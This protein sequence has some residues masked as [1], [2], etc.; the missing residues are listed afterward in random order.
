MAKDHHSWNNSSFHPQAFQAK[1]KL[2]SDFGNATRFIT[3]FKLD[4][5]YCPPMRSWLYWDRTRFRPDDSGQIL[6]LVARSVER[7]R[8]TADEMS[9]HD[10]AMN[11]RKWGSTSESRSRLESCEK[12]AQ[13]DPR[14]TVY[15][16]QLDSDRFLLNVQNGVIDLREG[17]LKKHDR[18]YLQS[19]IADVSYDPDAKCPIFDQ[20]LAR[21]S[22]G[23]PEWVSFIHRLFGYSLT[24]S[25]EEE[26]LFL[27]HGSGQNGKTKLLEIIGEILG[28]YG[29]TADF[30]TFLESDSDRIRNDIARMQGKR[31]ITAS[32]PSR[33][34]A[35]DESVVKQMTG[36]DTL[37]ARF[38]N[39]EFFEFTPSHTIVMATNDLPQVSGIDQGIWRRLVVVQFPV[40]ITDQERDN[41][42]L[43]KLQKEKSGILNRLV[44]GCLDW[45]KSGLEMPASVTQ[46]SADYRAEADSVWAFVQD[47][48]EQI[49]GSYVV[50]SELRT[51]YDAWC[52][53]H[54][55]TPA[56][57]FPSRLEVLGFESGRITGGTRIRY[58]LKLK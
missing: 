36:G 35:L 9:D 22:G 26:R 50:V 7:Y 53:T 13:S 12:I 32:E 47:A 56:V 44:Q 6:R 2:R 11:V 52:K 46:A 37:T 16:W 42:L 15:P 23:D 58:G 55:K 40:N 48:C 29:Q 18:K 4:I 45:Q 10:E 28:D 30:D 38:L 19:Q 25:T 3:D 31:L 41:K 54:G 1:S 51:A 21:I 14:V 43:D 20:F 57:K 49:P 34:K 17:V 5:R 39:K 27:L 33:K 8:Y 24:G